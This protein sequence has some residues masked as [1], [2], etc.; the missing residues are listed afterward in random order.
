MVERLPFLEVAVKSPPTF[1]VLIWTSPFAVISAFPPT[2]DLFIVALP[3]LDS[4]TN[5]SPTT[6]SSLIVISFLALIFALLPTFNLALPPAT[7]VAPNSSNDGVYL[8]F[9]A[10]PKSTAGF[11]ESVGI[12][13]PILPLAVNSYSAAVKIFVPSAIEFA[14]E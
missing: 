14:A 7:A 12:T 2:V 1:V 6:D 11:V 10:L 8:P 5:F 3:F 13:S 9:T 4:R